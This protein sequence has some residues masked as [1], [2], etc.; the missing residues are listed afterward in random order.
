MKD[1][2]AQLFLEALY[3]CS[4]E[5]GEP[6]QMLCILT[7]SMDWYCIV[8]DLR[9]V[10]KPIQF[11]ALSDCHPAGIS[12]AIL[13]LIFLVFI[14]IYTCSSIELDVLVILSSTRNKLFL[15]SCAICF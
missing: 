14:I 13:Q 9:K 11:N 15:Y 5:Q 10:R 2:L 1:D 3:C 6:R 8:P 12:S 4:N 7:N